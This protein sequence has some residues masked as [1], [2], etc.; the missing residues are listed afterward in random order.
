MKRRWAH[1][2]CLCL[3]GADLLAAGGCGAGARVAATG[4]TTLDGVPSQAPVDP[5]VNTA[6]M[7]VPDGLEIRWWVVRD[8]PAAII[9]ALTPYLNQPSEVDAAT[10]ARLR[11]AGLRLVAVPIAELPALRARLPIAG[12]IDRRW[13]GQAT[14]WIEGVAGATLAANTPVRIAN[15]RIDLTGGRLRLLAR[16]W[17][18]PVQTPPR[19]RIDLAVQ[20]EPTRPIGRGAETRPVRLRR[21][22]DEGFIFGSSLVEFSADGQFFFLLVPD[23]PER[24]WKGVHEAAP[25]SS[26]AHEEDARDTSGGD[27]SEPA[28]WKPEPTV[29]PEQVSGPPAPAV[30][31]LGE[32][33][34]IQ[35]PD[36]GGARRIRAIVVLVPRLAGPRTLLP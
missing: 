9:G 10:I 31:S 20:Q 19:L 16:A 21:D 23:A 27:S 36:P 7:A 29:N 4:S 15:E 13:V 34:L 24:A 26:G 6:A 35:S 11:N 2:I 33:L 14:D 5:I 22:V 8:D 32:A 1:T 12:R 25:N 17:T 3:C 18:E 30:A 28:Q